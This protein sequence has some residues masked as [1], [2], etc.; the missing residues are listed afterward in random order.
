MA[1]LNQTTVSIARDGDTSELQALTTLHYLALRYVLVCLFLRT[2]F[3]LI[4]FV[5]LAITSDPFNY[6]NIYSFSSALVFLKI[7]CRLPACNMSRIEQPE[8]PLLKDLAQQNVT[9]STSRQII[10]SPGHPTDFYT[11]ITRLLWQT[12]PEHL[13]ITFL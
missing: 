10:S 7:F 8:F 11:H 1:R 9:L 4:I 3:I 2:I 5:S 6:S 13:L 12:T